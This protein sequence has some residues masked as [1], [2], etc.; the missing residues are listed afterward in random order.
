MYCITEFIYGL[1]EFFMCAWAI[2]LI[3]LLCAQYV[4]NV[5]QSIID[6]KEEKKRNDMYHRYQA[7]MNKYNKG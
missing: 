3:V 6:N 2:N 5:K 1:F 7:K 4:N